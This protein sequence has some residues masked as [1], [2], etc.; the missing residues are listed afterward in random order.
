[1]NKTTKARVYNS[2]KLQELLDE[3]T[4]VEMEQTKI[5]MQLAARI[6]DFVRAKGWS[7]SQF[8]EKVGKNPSEITRWFS[9][10]HNFTI[11]VLTEIAF[12]LGIGLTELFRKNQTQVIDRRA[13]VV[14]SLGTAT[15]IT[16]ATPISQGRDFFGYSYLVSKRNYLHYPK[17][18][19]A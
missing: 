17:N 2:S 4:S 10:T 16:V 1:M 19:Q 3:V 18:Y 15:A 12:A 13:I 9:G 6:E 14:K 5:K 7:N 8:A 11:D